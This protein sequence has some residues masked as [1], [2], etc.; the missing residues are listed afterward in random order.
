MEARR[1][2][3]AGAPMPVGSL[4]M[5]QVAYLRVSIASGNKAAQ[6]PP[7]RCPDTSAL[8]DVTVTVLSVGASR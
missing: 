1:H 6:P 5:P 2:S 4:K 7:R 3:L 8:S